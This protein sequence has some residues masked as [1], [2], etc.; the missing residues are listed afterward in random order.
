MPKSNFHQFDTVTMLEPQAEVATVTSDPVDLD[1]YNGCTVLFH[2]GT[3]AALDSG[4]F[5]TCSLTECATVGGSY[6]AVATSNLEDGS[7]SASNPIINDTAEDGTAYKLTYIGKLRFIR[8]VITEASDGGD[9]NTIVAI[10]AILTRKRMG[11]MIQV[12]KAIAS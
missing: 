3:D 8:G 9:L 5:W 12:S 1:E 10:T 11:P 7:T 6:T 4:D 2:I